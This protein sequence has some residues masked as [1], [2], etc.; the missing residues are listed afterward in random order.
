MRTRDYF[1]GGGTYIYIDIHTWSLW[2][3]P[4]WGLPLFLLNKRVGCKNTG[5]SCKTGASRFEA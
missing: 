5:R 1:V 3:P 4:F 2:G